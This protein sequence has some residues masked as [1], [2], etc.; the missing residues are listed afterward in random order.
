M[1]TIIAV[2]INHDVPVLKQPGL[3]KVKKQCSLLGAAL[4]GCFSRKDFRW[5]LIFIELLKKKQAFLWTKLTL[6]DY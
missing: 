1:V 2:I 5:L 6:N 3:K 4:L